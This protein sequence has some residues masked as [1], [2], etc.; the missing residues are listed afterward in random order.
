MTETQA[1]DST[2]PATGHP[3]VGHPDAGRRAVGHPA[4]GHPDAG[5]RAEVMTSLR[6]LAIDVGVPLG[7]FY[8]LH[9]VFGVSLWLSLALSSIPPAIRA[10]AGFAAGRTANLLALLMLAVNL[11]GIVVSFLTGDRG[12]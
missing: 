8:L 1:C 2:R 5:R 3:A 10:V 9:D 12:P 11:A 7:G 4:V 6:P